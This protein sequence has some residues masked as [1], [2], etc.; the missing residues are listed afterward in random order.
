MYGRGEGQ[1]TG[2]EKKETKWDT[3]YFFSNYL[4]NVLRLP[5]NQALHG[6]FFLTANIFIELFVVENGRLYQIFFLLRLKSIV[7]YM[8]Q[9]NYSFFFLSL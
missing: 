2:K 5:D 7:S 4:D 6:S 3:S 1:T 9:R 8:H